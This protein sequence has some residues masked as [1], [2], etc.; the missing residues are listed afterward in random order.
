VQFEGVRSLV[1]PHRQ[2]TIA[3][4]RVSK[5]GQLVTTLEPRMSQYATMREPVGSPDVYST[6]GGDLYLSLLN[7]DEASQT[8]GVSVI[9]MPMV[10]WIWFSVILM[11]LGGLM[12]LIPPRRPAIPIPVGGQ[13]PSPVVVRPGQAR[14]PV[15]PQDVTS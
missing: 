1:E 11:G 5:N 10:G 7:I 3:T 13:A 2:S 4:F 14:A 6:L 8:V 15:P 12:A 9:T